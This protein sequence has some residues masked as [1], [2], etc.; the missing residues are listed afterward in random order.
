MVTTQSVLPLPMSS[1][2]HFDSNGFQGVKSR[3]LLLLGLLLWCGFTSAQMPDTTT[4]RYATQ[5][6]ANYWST[7][8][9]GDFLLFEA[10]GSNHS[11]YASLQHKNITLPIG[12]KILIWQGNYGR[13]YIDGTN[14]QG[15]E[16]QPTIITN[17]GG[18]V[19]WGDHETTVQYR[20]FEIKNFQHVYLTGKYD[21]TQ[22]T[23]DSSYLGHDNGNAYDTGDYY[24]K[25]GFWGNQRWAGNRL[26]VSNPNVIRAYGYLSFKAD[27]VAAWGGGF[28]CFNLKTDNPTTAERVSVDVQDCFT[29]FTEGEGFYISYSSASATNQDITRLTMR[30]N[31]VMCAGTEGIQTDR[32]TE[33]SIIEH[34]VIISAAADFR[35]PFKDLDQIAFKASVM[36][37]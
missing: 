2:N 33:G 3:V 1:G 25:Y 29:G 26:G 15:T 34:N 19:R 13:I 37:R 20:T 9:V 36:P 24:E 5:D 35:S 31:I 21:L 8:N 22:Q 32:L 11:I 27:Y 4:D 28:A 17:L 16:S 6:D 18:Q 7:V 30:N 23:G 14:C 12:K 10:N